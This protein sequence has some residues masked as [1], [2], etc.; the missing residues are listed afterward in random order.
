M[1]NVDTCGSMRGDLGLADVC[2]HVDDRRGG[3]VTQRCQ[4][5]YDLRGGQARD[6]SSSAFLPV[7]NIMK[8]AILAEF[9]VV[10]SHVFPHN[11][12]SGR[13]AIFL[14]R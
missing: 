6:F 10:A 1:L 13:H 8:M 9:G 3:Q 5:E 7:H 11:R 14:F 12:L 2:S 4:E